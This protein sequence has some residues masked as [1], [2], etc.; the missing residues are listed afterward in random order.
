MRSLCHQS[1]IEIDGQNPLEKHMQAMQFEEAA[2]QAG[3]YEKSADN[4]LRME[5]E[6]E[7]KYGKATQKLWTIFERTARIA[8]A[9]YDAQT[10]TV[11]IPQVAD[12]DEDIPFFDTYPDLPGAKIGEAG[13]AC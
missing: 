9:R 1:G 5:K 4:S 10:N 11:T 13:E 8:Q 7:I 2:H 6:A 3:Y 12:F